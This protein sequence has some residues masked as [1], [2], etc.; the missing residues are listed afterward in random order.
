MATRLWWNWVVDRKTYPDWEKLVYELE[1]S[2]IPTLAYINPFVTPIEGRYFPPRRL[3]DEALDQDFLVKDLEG[4]P[5]AIDSGG[6]EGYLIDF[7][8]DGARQWLID[9][10]KDEFLKKNVKG[11]MADFGEAL[12]LDTV[13]A[14]GEKSKAYHNQ[15]PVEWAKIQNEA[16][17][18][19]K[20]A[21][22]FKAKDTQPVVFH[23]SGFTK[24]P[25]EVGLFW[26]GD[27]LV[28]WDEHDGLKSSITALISAGLSGQTINHSDVGGYIS[29]TFP[30]M[31][32]LIRTRE[33]M[34]R[35]TELNTFTSFL[36]THE[37]TNPELGI[38]FDT[39]DD[40]LKFFAY[41]SRVFK[42]LF[43]Y[44]KAVFKEASAFGYPVVRPLFL[45][46]PDDQTALK[47]PYQFLMGKD[48]LVAPVTEPGV[49]QKK[50]YLPK[51]RWT[52]LWDGKNLLVGDKGAIIDVSAPLGYIPVFFNPSNEILKDIASA[53]RILERPMLSKN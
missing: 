12:P 51:G 16:I 40:I 14:N 7:T 44:R 2:N 25:A 43:L 22:P 1:D 6:F 36:R 53:I 13:M 11:W 28:S 27:Q 39:D 18:E 9:I 19:F 4:E 48:L 41:Y 34:K 17:E 35:W 21:Y 46:Y 8:A 23:R 42:E 37:G 24:S 31:P 50:V 52:N 30:F 26:L 20:K 38:Q 15:Y 33:L 29:M 5:V 10:I 32:N 49:D 47:F 45:H 3:F